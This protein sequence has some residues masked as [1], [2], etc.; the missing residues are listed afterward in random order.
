MDSD[1]KFLK[2]L[3]KDWIWIC[4]NLSDIYQELI[5]QYPLTSA[6]NFYLGPFPEMEVIYV[7]QI[8]IQSKNYISKNNANAKTRS[9]LNPNS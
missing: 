7:F 5:N 9:C 6:S 3:D 8:Q 2:F 1:T 4:K